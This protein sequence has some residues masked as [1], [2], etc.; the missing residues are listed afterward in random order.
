[1]NL[2]FIFAQSLVRS[3]LTP[4]WDFSKH[5]RFLLFCP[6]LEQDWSLLL[7]LTFLNYRWSKFRFLNRVVSQKAFQGSFYHWI[8]WFCRCFRWN[9]NKSECFWWKSVQTSRTRNPAQQIFHLPIF[10]AEVRTFRRTNDDS[11]SKEWREV[12]WD[13]RLLPTGFWSSFDFNADCTFCHCLRK[14]F[15]RSNCTEWKH[16][17][18]SL[19][20]YNGEKTTKF[21]LCFIHFLLNGCFFLFRLY[22]QGYFFSTFFFS[23]LDRIEKPLQN[24]QNISQKALAWLCWRRMWWKACSWDKNGS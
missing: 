21:F 2:S 13:G 19:Q 1:M 9:Q 3:S 5:F 16:V 8:S 24:P 22:L 20:L 23:L 17:R 11:N 4:G 10:C 15:L 18:E 12:L 7:Q 6:L 14:I